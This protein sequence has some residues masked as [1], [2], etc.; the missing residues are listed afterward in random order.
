MMK[1][2]V[3]VRPILIAFTLLLAACSATAPIS[4]DQAN[5]TQEADRVTLTIQ[6]GDKTHTFNIEV[7]RT[8]QEQEKGL[9]FRKFLPDDGG[10]LFP[11]DPPQIASFWMKNTVIP[12]DIL[13]IRP[14]GTISFIAA[15]TE[16]YSLVPVS[17]GQIDAAVLE[18]AGGRAEALGIKAEDAVRWETPSE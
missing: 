6:S 5:A 7:A 18:I 17:S 11:F 2:N 15:N 8:S 4:S 14:D 10:M 13:F 16:P 3:S 12:L 9:M 1:E